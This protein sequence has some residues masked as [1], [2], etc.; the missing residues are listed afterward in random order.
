MDS[1]EWEP[2]SADPDLCP[3]SVVL[4]L[5]GSEP[6]AHPG[7]IDGYERLRRQ[8]PVR[9]ISVFPIFGPQGV[10]RGEAFWDDVVR[11]ANDQEATLVVFQYYHSRALPDPRRAIQRLHQLRSRPF[12]VST[13]G[14]PFINGYLGRPSI[15]RSFLQAAEDSD[16]VTLT[17]M[18][19]MAEKVREYTNAPIMLCPNGACQVRF[20]SA[21]GIVDDHDKAYDVAFVGSRNMS[22]NPLRPFHWFGKRRSRLVE[23]LSK[24]FGKRFAVYGNGWDYLPSARGSVPFAQQANAVR[25]ARVVVGGIPFSQER[26]YTSNRPFIQMTSGVPIVDVRVPGVDLILKDRVH[27]VLSDEARLMD[28]IEEV[29]T[30]TSEDRAAMGQTAADYVLNRHTQAHRVATLVE[31]VQRLRTWRDENIHATP[32]LPFFHDDMAVEAET[33]GATRNWPGI[34]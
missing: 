31:N 2:V 28:T 24:R 18:G 32:Y 7:I 30:W 34:D 1:V 4:V 5:Q 6:D 16:L 23:S 25:S 11:R 20:G 13:L 22:R 27:W 8:G 3:E 26:Y 15:P 9:E 10:V 29:L 33:P 21:V 12:V 19:A 17:S 14:D